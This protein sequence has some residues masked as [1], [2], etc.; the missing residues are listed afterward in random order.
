MNKFFKVVLTLAIAGVAVAA[1]VISLINISSVS[2]L[3]KKTKKEKTA[4]D[5][6]KKKISLEEL[7]LNELMEKV[8]S[9][10]AAQEDLLVQV[11]EEYIGRGAI[12]TSAGAG[13]DESVDRS[14][15]NVDRGVTNVDRTATNIDRSVTNRYVQYIGG[16]LWTDDGTYIYP[17]NAGTSFNITDTGNLT[18]SGDLAVN[19]GDLTTTATTF[20]LLNTTATTL[21]IG[22]AATTVEVGA[23]TGTTSVN[24]NLTVDGNTTLGD[25]GVD[26]VI[27]N[28]AAW[29]FANDTAVALTGGIDGLNFDANTLSI[30]ATNNRVGI[31]TA[32]PTGGKLEISS[33]A[34][35][36]FSMIR[37]VSGQWLNMADGTDIFGVYNRAGTPE[38]FIAANTGS[39]A[40]N[41]TNGTLYAKTTD[42]VATGWVQFGTAG[43]GA[44]STTANVTSNAPGDLALDDFVFGS[45][46]LDDD[47][48][49]NHDNRMFFDKSTGAFRAGGV[50]GTQWDSPG[51]YSF[52]SGRDTVAMGFGSIAMGNRAVASGSF[53]TAMGSDTFATG[54]YSTAMGSST[55]ASGNNS[56]TMGYTTTAEPYASVVLG[57]YNV[58]SAG[59]NKSGWTA[60]D[61]LFVIGNGVSAGS[62]SNAMTVLKNGDVGIGT[63]SPNEH[64]EV[65]GTGDQYI[66]V[67][68]TDGSTPG[69]KLIDTGAGNYDW[70]ASVQQDRLYFD[71]SVDDGSSWFYNLTFGGVQTSS[72]IRTW[73]AV[74]DLNLGAGDDI[75][76][77]TFSADWDER[78][79]ITEAGDVGIGTTVPAYDL[80]VNGD[81]R[82]IG[83]VYYGGTVGNANGILYTKPDFVFEEGYEVMSVEQVE[84]YLRVEN[85]LPWMTSVKQ[86]KEENGDVIDMTRMAFE[87]VETAENLQLQIIGLNTMAGTQQE[88]ISLLQSGIGEIET[89]VEQNTLAI[90][91]LGDVLSNQQTQAQ[92]LGEISELLAAQQ[93]QIDNLASS[94]QTSEI[95]A[96][97][98]KLVARVDSLEAKLL[99][100]DSPADDKIA[101]DQSQ[102]DA[103]QKPVE[104]TDSLAQ[105]NEFKTLLDKLVARMDELEAKVANG[106]TTND[107]K[108]YQGQINAQQKQIDELKAQNNS[109]KEQIDS[110]KS[111]L[112]AKE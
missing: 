1:L 10:E 61:P 69:I 57:R 9:Q 53:S 81:I 82:A 66:Q 105:N 97:L 68:S 77:Q 24:N 75:I 6:L 62:R 67:N 32:A 103:E 63:S 90:S 88:Q 92:S 2:S 79:R 83:S 28:A 110:I 65:S 40:V 50:T 11:E 84:E 107:T 22:G 37:T 104:S 25:A 14:V 96:S 46:Q 55:N 73:S 109:L 36:P 87:T 94:E 18:T 101:E 52:A 29:T 76:F 80:D 27:S 45:D 34:T 42:T 70:R 108:D 19:G 13:V 93:T 4:M 12:V 3:Q 85:H 7:S 60:T 39:L 38:T 95:K 15:T 91:D 59:Y 58:T 49:T 106:S 8:D 99:K 33:A 72:Q 102:T 16:G 35:N 86:E 47:G 41:T 21:N 112:D 20:N 48:D 74:A 17:N 111:S 98:G 44:F 100:A 54:S 43:S 26:T 51:S 71:Y 5:R 31:G 78:M 23:T 30:D 64:L 89:D 56:T